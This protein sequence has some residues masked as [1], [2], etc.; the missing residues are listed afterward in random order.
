MLDQALPGGSF[1]SGPLGGG[2]G[3]RAA[4]WVTYLSGLE[5][6]QVTYLSGLEGIVGQ[7][8]YLPGW[9]GERGGQVTYL[10]GHFFVIFSDHPILR[11]GICK[12]KLA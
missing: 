2:V 9:E 12:P 7:V 11:P 4:W 5:S 3:Q 6:R 1:H 10:P 8:T